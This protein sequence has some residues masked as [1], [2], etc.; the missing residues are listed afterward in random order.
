MTGYSPETI[1]TRRTRRLGGWT[2]AA[3][4]KPR[5]GPAALTLPRWRA[6]SA[7]G[8]Q[9]KCVGG[10]VTCPFLKKVSC[11]GAAADQH[12]DTAPLVGRATP[13]TLES[14]ALPATRARRLFLVW[15][16]CTIHAA[17][18]D[19]PA[20]AV[21]VRFYNVHRVR[22]SIAAFSERRWNRQALD[23]GAGA[24]GEPVPR[25]TALR[26]PSR[27]YTWRELRHD[28]PQSS[29]AKSHAAALL[30]REQRRR[31]VLQRRQ[32]KR[33]VGTSINCRLT[34]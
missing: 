33:R 14:G 13:R 3:A 27:V 30:Q 12:S 2:A 26:L 21:A 31:R 1:R 23:G 11:P 10:I 5:A 4:D 17:A 9:V 16:T 18:T 22:L 25:R 34:F 28:T 8:A 20:A 6:V 32:L 24:D 15:N 19:L 29:G 7:A